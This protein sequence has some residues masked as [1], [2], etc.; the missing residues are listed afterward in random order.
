MFIG[1]GF[2]S[3]AVESPFNFLV[4]ARRLREIGSVGILTRFISE[5]SVKSKSWNS[6]ACVLSR[7][8]C[9]CPES[10]CGTAGEEAQRTAG[11]ADQSN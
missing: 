1:S 9:G 6:T 10:M 2:V 11:V 5:V 8:P 3:A 7:Q 4:L